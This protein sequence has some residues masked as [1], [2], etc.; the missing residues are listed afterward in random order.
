LYKAIALKREDIGIMIRSFQR[1]YAM[2]ALI[3]S[4]LAAIT[5]AGAALAQSA[6]TP[7][8]TYDDVQQTLT[9]TMSDGSSFLYIDG[10]DQLAEGVFGGST[11]EA[12]T[13]YVSQAGQFGDGVASEWILTSDS[14]GSSFPPCPNDTIFPNYSGDPDTDFAPCIAAINHDG[15]TYVIGTFGTVTPDP[16]TPEGLI[17]TPGTVSNYGEAVPYAL[18]TTNKWPTPLKGGAQAKM[19]KRGFKV[20]KHSEIP[21]KFSKKVMKVDGK[22]LATMLQFNILKKDAHTGNYEFTK[23]YVFAS[24]SQAAALV[25]NKLVNGWQNWITTLQSKGKFIPGLHSGN[26]RTLGQLYKHQ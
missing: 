12:R 26:T 19:T 23:D 18:P 11:N 25:A 5:C 7:V 6:P 1:G 9:I 16:G 22:L 8:Y 20:L 3:I 4:A 21:E 13:E 10:Q 14:A 2:R 17:F 24:P 15:G